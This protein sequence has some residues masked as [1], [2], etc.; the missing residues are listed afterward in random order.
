M[1]TTLQPVTIENARLLFKNFAGKEGAF[2]VAGARN[3]AVVL[4]DEDAAAMAADGWNVKILI[5]KEEGD[6]NVPYL[7]VAVGYKG[8]PPTIIVMPEHDPNKR[9][10][11]DE[12]TVEMLDW[13]DIANV[14][15]MV[16]PYEWSS[17][18]KTGIKAYL[19]SMYVTVRQ[20]ALAVKY[21]SLNTN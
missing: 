6:E 18:G 1:S 17:N 12:E 10:H 14:D 7:P 4:P 8:R 19:Q 5:A 9:S 11:L 3:F 13:A 21:D 2:N 15:L 20:D 16:R